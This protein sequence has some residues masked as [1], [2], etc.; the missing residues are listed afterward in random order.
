[1]KAKEPVTVCPVGGA[2]Q[3]VISGTK[4]TRSSTNQANKSGKKRMRGKRVTKEHVA[5]CTRSSTIQG[6]RPLSQPKK[7][8]IK[9][10]TGCGKKRGG[11]LQAQGLVMG[12]DDGSK[13]GT[14]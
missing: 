11:Y 3:T 8:T 2:T 6:N 14:P 1:M 5:K 12:S 9:T 7:P 4:L 10:R 13:K